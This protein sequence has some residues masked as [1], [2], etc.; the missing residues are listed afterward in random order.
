M[1]RKKAEPI[2]MDEPTLY[3][4]GEQNTESSG[5]LEWGAEAAA[6]PAFE[7]AVSD[8]QGEAEWLE[9][10]SEEYDSCDTSIDTLA[11]A[12]D[13]PTEDVGQGEQEEP[14]YG[15]LLDDVRE[16]DLNGVE[17]EKPLTLSDDEILDSE[18]IDTAPETEDVSERI[19]NDARAEA[20][21]RDRAPGRRTAA[22][23]PD[24]VLTIDAHDE[25][26]TEE[27]QEATLW[28]DIQNA[29]RTHRILTGT[30]DS[31][32][33]T[34]AGLTVVVVNYNDY[35]VAI[36]LKEMMVTRG[37]M[38]AG[39][40]Y[41]EL[42][43][44]LNRNMNARIG[45]EIDFVVKGIENKSRTVVASRRDA[46][47]RKRQHFYL[48]TDEFGNRMIYEGRVVQA[49]VVAVAEKV[50]R[51][52]VFGVECAIRAPQM[53]WE[54]IEDARERYFVGER[55]LV[56]VV[57]INGAS[58]EELSVKVD[59]RSITNTSRMDALNRCVIGSRYAGKVTD[60]R[61]GVVF[62]VLN[63]RANAI[64]HTSHD[65]RRPGKRDDVV[66]T[67]TKLDKE[68]GVAIGEIIRI[69]RQNL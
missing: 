31:V 61:N 6:D 26:E 1:A 33:R 19:E 37:R 53:S 68:Q 13:E 24:R 57:K 65:P 63:N 58:A 16:M 38:P 22:R 69:I 17:D 2:P 32:E 34:S 42:M 9:E 54:W 51:V 45:S 49:R 15:S 11:I 44:Q 29:Y 14:D 10:G 48:N 52:E 35:R 67:V 3:E 23:K 62:L 20:E 30:L 47:L 21:Q 12:D 39:R 28:H 46:M 4:I 56:R 27:E 59:T 7:S 8:G 55:I 66:F 5:G 43:V 25:I 64:A 40:E 36:P 60:V 18:E 41:E 50:V